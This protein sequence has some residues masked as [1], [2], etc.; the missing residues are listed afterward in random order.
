MKTSLFANLPTCDPGDFR[1]QV[2]L[3]VETITND[4][5]GSVQKWAPAFP[6][7]N[8]WSRIDYVRGTDLIRGGQDVTQTYI[9]VTSWFRKEFQT[10]CRIQVPGGSQF[11][12]QN[13][14]NVK[15]MNTYMVLTCLG[16]GEVSI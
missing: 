8:A 6:A 1:D 4:A 16:L 13:V 5:S 14:E 2:T 12:I 7:T 15:S 9:K 3:L 11:Q 10:N